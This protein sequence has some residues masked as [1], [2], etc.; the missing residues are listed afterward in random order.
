M[1][2]VSEMNGIEKIA[3]K[4][5]KACINWEI[6]GLY[7]CYQD[8]EE[9]YIPDTYEEV[10]DLVYWGCMNNLYGVGYCGSNKA[11]REMRFA[12]EKFIKETV[13]GCLRKD[14][15]VLFLAELKG[16]QM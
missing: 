15:D 12:G 1:K 8:G 6:G 13:D 7:N 14:E 5:I 3:Y 9:E 2:K 11:P 4:N 16:W 10:F